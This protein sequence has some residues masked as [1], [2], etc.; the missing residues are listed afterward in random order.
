[1]GP[2]AADSIPS[3]VRSDPGWLR[4]PRFDIR[5]I[6]GTAALALVTGWVVVRQ[7]GLFVPIFLLDIWLL[8]YHHVVSTYT[9]LCFD[10]ESF[11]KHRFLVLWLPLLVL[12]TTAALAVG[13]GFWA[14]ATIYLYWQWF[15]YTR[16][17]FGI[18]QIYRRR[19]D[20]RVTDNE[21]LSRWIFYLVPLWG[22]LHRSHQAPDTFLALE[23]RVIPVTDVAV[24]AVAAAAIIGL[25]WWIW[26]RVAEWRRGTLPVAY[27]LYML[28]HFA[29]FYV[30]Y[31]LIDDINV[32][33]LVLNI[34]HNAQYI[35]FVW[36][37][38]NKRFNNEVDPKA[39]FL[40][41]LSQ[42]RNVWLYVLVCLAIS[43]AIYALIQQ[44][45]AGL[46][47]LVVIY[48]TINYHHYIVDGVIWKVRRKS[49]RETLGLA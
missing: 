19:A 49:L 26:Q 4:S 47:P 20:G 7:P 8:G 9:R 33:W 24:N 1:M 37:F 41:R 42:R 3:G 40:S 17:S 2:E 29:V 30:G 31:I 16:Q 22:I 15:H 11:R 6:I 39:R 35:A 32:G 21:R 48:Q 44:T 14:L 10:A 45:L 38:N 43:T 34:W 5:F 27:T 25:A 36:L 28:S 12:A 23:L 18:S 13:V 46:I